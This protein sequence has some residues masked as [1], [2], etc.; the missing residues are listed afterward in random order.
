MRAPVIRLTLISL[1]LAATTAVADE[2]LPV[3][4]QIQLLSKMS[5]YI[6]NMQPQGGSGAIKILVV[7]PGDAPTRGAQSLLAALKQ[8]GKFGA[9]DTEA[10]L[11]P[12][13]DPTI[14]K[15]TAAA[16]KPQ[17]IYLA[18]ELDAQAVSQIVSASQGL[19]VVTLASA[20]DHPKLGVMIGFSIVE[21]RPRVLVNLK[22]ARKEN[23]EFK[24]QF[25]T[26][27]VIVEK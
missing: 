16:E 26:K 4:L 9:F 22:H 13:V 2:D 6:P 25:L 23:V 17:I 24:N 1:L 3:N 5:T 18:A 10:K 14:L 11:V 20:A 21:A 19:K 12:Y 15:T 7:H 27:T 8:V